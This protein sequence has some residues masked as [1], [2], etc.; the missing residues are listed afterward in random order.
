MTDR[1]G[2]GRI[3]VNEMLISDDAMRALINDERATADAIK[4]DA[5]DRLGMTTSFRDGAVKAV[6]GLVSIEEV[7]SRLEAGDKS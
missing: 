3:G 2:R 5:V 6:E 1:G 7:I 4:R